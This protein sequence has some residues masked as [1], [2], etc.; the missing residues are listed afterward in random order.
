MKS[1][2]RT[3]RTLLVLCVVSGA[4]A[5]Q[6]P[7]P[8]PSVQLPPA[9]ARVLRDYERHWRAGQADS[10]AQLFTEDGVIR[11]GGGW[12]RGRAAIRVAYQGTSSALQLRAV[13]Y[14]M[15]GSVGYI[16]GAYGTGP[17]PPVPD[18]GSFILSIRQDQRGFWR[19]A[20]DL[21][22]SRR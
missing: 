9:L 16:V 2:S 3:V 18:Q 14:A 20:A 12:I 7:T 1:T 6:A 11:S 21:D 4:A 15:D 19:I 13:A 5:A 8:L 17:E 10:L 22:A